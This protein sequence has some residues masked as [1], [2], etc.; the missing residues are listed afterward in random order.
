MSYHREVEVA[1][2]LP[3]IHA[4][5]QCTL[6]RDFLGRFIINQNYRCNVKALF[7]LR[8]QKGI[9]LTV[10]CWEMLTTELGLQCA[11]SHL[12]FGIHCWLKVEGYSCLHK[13]RLSAP[14]QQFEEVPELAR[15]VVHL[16]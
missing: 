8:V 4:N 7:D 16:L 14:A 2:A 15:Q 12:Q 10:L 1:P 9:K 13:P 6:Q 11:P 3:N 5:L